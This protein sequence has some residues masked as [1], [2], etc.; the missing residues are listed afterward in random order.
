M[1][2]EPSETATPVIE[3]VRAY[4]VTLDFIEEQRAFFGVWQTRRLSNNHARSAGSSPILLNYFAVSHIRLRLDVLVRRCRSLHSTDAADAQAM[5]ESIL[6]IE[7]FQQSLPRLPSRKAIV[8]GSAAVVIGLPL[9]VGSTGETRFLAD[10]FNGLAAADV[11]GV[12]DS[13]DGV[14]LYVLVKS[15]ALLLGLALVLLYLQPERSRSRE[16]SSMNILPFQRM[17]KPSLGE[18]WPHAA[19][20]F[21]TWRSGTCVRSD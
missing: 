15:V 21:T 8:T 7:E 3:L 19:V 2:N 10:V 16:R 11:S 13:I 4:R 17:E 1:G 18:T 5:S 6:R 14:D 20:A 9:L 12:V